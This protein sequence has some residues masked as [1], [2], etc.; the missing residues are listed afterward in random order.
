MA[1]ILD[2]IPE[3]YGGS[4]ARDPAAFRV[5]VRHGGHDGVLEHRTPA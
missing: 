3:S 4:G 1:L 5:E 2:F